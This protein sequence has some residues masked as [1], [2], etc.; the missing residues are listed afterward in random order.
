[1]PMDFPSGRSTLS[2]P[3]VEI[4][5]LSP[6][7]LSSAANASLQSTMPTNELQ[8][9]Y[10]GPDTDASNIASVQLAVDRLKSL[11]PSTLGNDTELRVRVESLSGI[12]SNASAVASVVRARLAEMGPCPVVAVMGEGFSFVAKAVEEVVQA[13]NRSIMVSFSAT[14]SDLTAGTAFPAFARVVPSDALQ[15]R[16]LA[17]TWSK[18]NWFFG[19]AIG[20]QDEP[21]SSALV[22]GFTSV[23]KERGISLLPGGHPLLIPQGLV[24]ATRKSATAAPSNATVNAIVE[25]LRPMQEAGPRVVFLGMLQTDAGPVLSAAAKL[26][27]TGANG[28]LWVTSDAVLGALERVGVG[29]TPHTAFSGTLK[30]GVGLLL[31]GVASDVQEAL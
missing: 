23:C 12:H 22:A 10:D 4:L 5:L 2:Q 11:Y 3:V 17:D 16:S 26:G 27:M 13:S 19:A 18:F 25:L 30:G 20:V 8:E 21:Y 29:V 6:L 31:H 28:Y 1:V 14:S 24:S 9:L 7:S 15:A